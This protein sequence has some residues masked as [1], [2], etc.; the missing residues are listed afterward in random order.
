[1][2]VRRFMRVFIGSPFYAGD[3]QARSTEP[4]RRRLYE[5]LRGA[6]HEPWLWEHEGIAEQRQ[7][8]G[9]PAYEVIAG[10]IK[11]ADAVVAFYD[12]RL[13][14]FFASAPVDEG[15]V[16][17][18]TEFEIFAGLRSFKPILVAFLHPEREPFR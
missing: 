6:G 8:L 11:R 13:G 4:M 18:A 14:S 9:M 12:R 3:G 16:F 1:M 10:A 17:P 5:R 7:A 2:E 15:G